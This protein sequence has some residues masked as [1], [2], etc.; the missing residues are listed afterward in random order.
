M[1]KLSKLI[2]ST[3]P[4]KLKEKVKWKKLITSKLLLSVACA[5]FL[6]Y[7]TMLIFSQ[8]MQ[9][10]IVTNIKFT[11]NQFDHFPAITICYDRLY[12]FERI[13]TRFDQYDQLYVNYTNFTD[14]LFDRHYRIVDHE[15]E[16]QAKTF[17]KAYNSMIQKNFPIIFRFNSGNYMSYLDIFENFTIPFMVDNNNPFGQNIFMYFRGRVFG[18][19]KLPDQIKYDNN[20]KI[21][22]ISMMPLESIDMRNRRKCFTFFSSLEPRYRNLTAMIESITIGISFPNNWFPFRETTKIYIAIHSNTMMPH[23]DSFIEIDQASQHKII[24]TKIENQQTV[25]HARCIDY[26]LDYKH[27]NFNMKSDC[28]YDCLQAYFDPY[29]TPYGSYLLYLQEFPLRKTQLDRIGYNTTCNI[30]H[31]RNYY[32]NREACTIKCSDACYQAYFLLDSK[33]TYRNTNVSTMMLS[34]RVVLTL[35]PNSMPNVVINHLAEMTILSL[36]CNFGG[37]VGMWLGI[38]VLATLNN[39]IHLT[40][41]LFIKLY[42]LTYMYKQNNY[43]SK[44]NLFVVTN[45]VIMRK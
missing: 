6:F 27:G 16:E 3:M 44:N 14:K 17:E 37:L 35:I 22:L 30:T 11:K 41:N 24:Y 32:D 23:Q 8:F 18:E 25:T 20:S 34:N 43:Y 13:V 45:P 9:Q 21:Y 28:V 4:F 26:D 7:Q 42:S 1:V 33:Q 36:F 10:N 2:N 19:N 40:K 15:T 31:I 39:L 29:C 12:S 38:S 5:S